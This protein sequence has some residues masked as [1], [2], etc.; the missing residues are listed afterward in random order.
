MRLLIATGLY[1]PDIGGPATYT[2]FLEKH[3]ASFGVEYEVLPYTI[4]R[5][6][7]RVVRHI[8]VPSEY[9]RKLVETWGVPSE[10]ITRIYSTPKS[11][12]ILETK[13][14]LRSQFQYKDFI[15]LTACRLVPWKGVGALIEVVKTLR[16][17]QLPISLEILGDGVCR[18]ELEE[19]VTQLG[20]GA[21]VTFRGNL[22]RDEMGKRIKASDVFVLNTSYEGLSHQLI[23]VMAIGTPIVT[24]PV[25]GNVEL[26][27]HQQTGILAP[28]NDY[29]KITEAIV[30]LYNN[31]SQRESRALR[32]REKSLEFKEEKVINEFV[33][34]LRKIS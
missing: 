15:V 11:I 10:K 14:A 27:M 30:E 7:P 4:V 33:T 22:D 1:P 8:I 5:K 17:K 26:I 25:G 23:E 29:E 6:Y 21:F 12:E 9:M 18:K 3:L 2:K 31:P 24:T 28:F 19:K 20:M 34:V 16:D 32:A 13:E